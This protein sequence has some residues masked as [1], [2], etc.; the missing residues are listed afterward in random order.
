MELV[1]K[2]K[3]LH[4]KSAKAVVEAGAETGIVVDHFISKVF[5]HTILF[6]IFLVLLR[7]CL[8]LSFHLLKT[9]NN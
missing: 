5:A 8:V 4:I 1:L 2:T 7:N 3:Y 6:I 9:W